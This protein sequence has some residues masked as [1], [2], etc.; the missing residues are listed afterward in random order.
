MPQVA[1]ETVAAQPIAAVSARVQIKEIMGAWEPALYQVKTFLADHS[2]LSGSGRHVFL[3]H[4]PARRDDAMQIDFGIEVARAFNESGAVKC[5]STPA[6][7]VATATHVGPLT[8]LPQTHKAI[9]EWCAAN[10][11]SIGAF[12]WET[13]VWGDGP[14]P[15]ET[16]VRYALR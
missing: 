6:G 1:L 14:D 15:V 8:S 4:H 11:H 7:Q 3:Y 13:Y 2:D 5:V 16:I 12:S 9:H 10:G